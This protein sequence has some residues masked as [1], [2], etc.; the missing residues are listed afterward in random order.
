M[1]E[2]RCLHVKVQRRQKGRRS[3]A[4]GTHGER[5]ECS[6]NVA[7]KFNISSLGRRMKAPGTPE[8]LHRD[9]VL[10]TVVPSVNF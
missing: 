6:M 8:Q 5:L 7:K 10:A 1:Y 4:E 9:M 3:K 2:R